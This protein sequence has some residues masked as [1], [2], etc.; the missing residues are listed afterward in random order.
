LNDGA[1]VDRLVL[2]SDVHVLAAR[3]YDSNT[4]T[5][6]L[7]YLAWL[8]EMAS[9]KPVGSRRRVGGDGELEAGGVT[10]AS[11]RGW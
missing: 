11:W 2:S 6:N 4:A 3:H 8:E 10:T 9:L 7:G 5:A 1:S